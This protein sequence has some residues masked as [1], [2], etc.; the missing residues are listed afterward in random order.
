MTANLLPLNSSKTE[1][2]LIGLKKQLDKIHNSSLD[3][4]HSARN[5]GFI[6]DHGRRSVGG[7]GDMSP[8]LFEVEGTPCVLSPLLSGI[9]IF[10][11]HNCTAT[12]TVYSSFDEC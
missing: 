4:T 6:F 5:L 7:Q 9:D 11:M 1:F 2:L 8:L 10:V 3:T 12:I